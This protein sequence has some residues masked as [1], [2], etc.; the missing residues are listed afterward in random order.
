MYRAAAAFI[1]FER[2]IGFLQTVRLYERLS[3]VLPIM[4]T[5]V[6]IGP[7]FSGVLL[8]YASLIQALGTFG[9]WSVAVLMLKR[10]RL[11]FLL[12]IDW[13]KD[14]NREDSE[15]DNMYMLQI[16]WTFFTIF[17]FSIS[18]MN[19]I[20]AIIGQAY[21]ALES[22]HRELYLEEKTHQV[23][24]Y[25]LAMKATAAQA[26]F[27]KFLQKASESLFPTPIDN[28]YLWGCYDKERVAAEEVGNAG[29]NTCAFIR[30]TVKTTY[31]DAADN[32]Y[33]KCA[34]LE[35]KTRGRADQTRIGIR[36]RNRKIGDLVQ[37][38]SKLYDLDMATRRS[39][40]V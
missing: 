14:M 12:D 6:Y 32:I 34:D 15:S 8:V 3:S 39:E 29:R 21:E 11:D 13:A 26:P 4:K 9:T 36:S 35:A 28:A 38:T 30:K 37:Q 24:S 16:F 22:K 33:R 17:V 25:F 23:F 20:V 7:F 31:T 40:A 5:F 19:V 2:W 1:A 10:Y 18:L 27:E